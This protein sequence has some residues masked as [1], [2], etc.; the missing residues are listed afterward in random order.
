MKI[1]HRVKMA[2]KGTKKMALNWVPS[3]FDEPDLKKAKK[4]GFLP[5]AAPVI[6]PGNERVP[7]PP[8]G[9]RCFSPFSVMAFLFLPMNFFVGFSL[10]MACSFISS[11]RIQFCTLLVL[12]LFVNI[13]LESIH[14]RSFGNSFF[15]FAP[16]FFWAKILSWG[17]LL[18]L[19]D[20]N[21]I[22]WSSP[23]LR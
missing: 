22:I 17:E 9:Y 23:W 4:E 13:L 16:A 10:F 18:Y 15:A 6:F 11:R 3:S 14:T 8:K 20:L 2:K 12:S 5:A 19:C 7:K 21:R 1:A